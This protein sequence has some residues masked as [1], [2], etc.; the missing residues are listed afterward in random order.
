MG[1]H[2]VTYEGFESQLGVNYLSHF[3][4]TEKLLEKT[5]LLSPSDDRPPSKIV[6]V[7]SSFHFAVDGSDLWPSEGKDPIAAQLGG[8][9]G[10]TVF[11][12]QRQYA[13]SKL[14]QILHARYYNSKSVAKSVTACPAWVGT[15]IIQAHH[16]SLSARI[17]RYLAF[18]AEGYGLSSILAAMFADDDDTADD[19]YISTQLMQG[20]ALVDGVFSGSGSDTTSNNT[21]SLSQQIFYHWTPFRDVAMFGGAMLIMQWQR[22]FPVVKETAQSSQASYN[23]KLQEEFYQWSKT[24][25]QEWV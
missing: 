5:S 23:T 11:R 18:S 2:A 7:T 16:E 22:F 9:H 20:G 21:L 25:V 10:F 19:F 17:F 8:N 13:N 24:A 12:S 6:H 1:P 3:L 14:A 4:L 15:G